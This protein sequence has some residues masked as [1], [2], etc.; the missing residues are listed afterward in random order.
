MDLPV[1]C[2]EQNLAITGSKVTAPSTPFAH[3]KKS[4]KKLIFTLPSN[5]LES[6]D[7]D[8]VK[9]LPAAAVG[10]EIGQTWPL[11]SSRFSPLFSCSFHP[12]LLT[13]CE[14]YQ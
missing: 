12:W 13:S 9:H 14:A 6:T 7:L 8:V 10:I 3:K 2:Y 1:L 11:T 5:E 4:Q